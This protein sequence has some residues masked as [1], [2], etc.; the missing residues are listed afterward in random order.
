MSPEYI[1]VVFFFL[2]IIIFLTNC[3]LGFKN[4]SIV[5]PTGPNMGVGF[6]TRGFEPMTGRRARVQ[7]LWGI[8]LCIIALLVLFTV[9][10]E[11]F[12]ENLYLNISLAS[13]VFVAGIV[14]G[15][16]SYRRLLKRF[17]PSFLGRD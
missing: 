6:G 7:S 14:L 5:M 4:K 16:I 17:D 13:V 8:A 2:S 9:V 15:C 11:Y 3:I 1:V 12:F 10:K